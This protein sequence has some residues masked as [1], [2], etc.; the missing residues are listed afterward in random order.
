MLSLLSIIR[1]VM[2]TTVDATPDRTEM[3][4]RQPNSRLAKAYNHGME[5]QSETSLSTIIATDA[6]TARRVLPDSP[7]D[8]KRRRG[9]HTKVG[10]ESSQG[11]CPFACQPE[12][13]G[14]LQDRQAAALV[15][16]LW[17][18]RG[19]AGPVAVPEKCEGLEVVVPNS[20]Q[21]VNMESRMLRATVE[22]SSN[23]GKPPSPKLRQIHSTSLLAGGLALPCGMIKAAGREELY[24]GG[25]WP[26]TP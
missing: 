24:S 23:H 13:T 6:Y 11:S 25:R 16:G 22:G 15:A 12:V 1:V 9:E 3:G 5:A 4:D 10:Y 20:V 8:D 21:N 18:N 17:L 19:E 7:T 14:N 26:P 2:A